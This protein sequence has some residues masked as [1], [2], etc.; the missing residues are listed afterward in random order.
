MERY[1]E[2]M[3]QLSLDELFFIRGGDGGE[4][5]PYPP[6]PPPPPPP[7]SGTGG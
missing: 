6:P 2:T 4:E 5:V 3:L 1:K 7:P